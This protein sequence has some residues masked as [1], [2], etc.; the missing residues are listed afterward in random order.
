MSATSTRAIKAAGWTAEPGRFASRVGAGI[1]AE[2]REPFPF[3]ACHRN[4]GRW[5]ID[6][7]QVQDRANAVL[8]LAWSFELAGQPT[9]EAARGKDQKGN[10]CSGFEAVVSGHLVIDLEVLGL[11]KGPV[12]RPGSDSC[13]ME[14]RGNAVKGATSGAIVKAL[15][16]F[17]VGRELY[18]RDASRRAEL[19]T[20]ACLS[21]EVRKASLAGEGLLRKQREGAL[22][23]L[24]TLLQQKTL[25][26]Q[27]DAEALAA[28]HG[29]ELA[30]AVKEACGY[31]ATAELTPQ[32][33]ANLI[34]FLIEDRRGIANPVL[35]YEISAL[36]GE[37]Q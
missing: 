5:Y 31:S 10:P 34:T 26:W 33:K 11:A 14:S 29:A 6:G 9:V 36:G 30:A 19:E 25:A 28:L 12:K 16:Y 8:G 27:A 7:Y 13:F 37:Q 2:L 17:G 18:G 32:D 15:S 35:P 4:D 22:T 23:E 21:A 3:T 20:L 1:L 24:K